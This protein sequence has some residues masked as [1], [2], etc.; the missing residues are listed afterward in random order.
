MLGAAVARRRRRD[1]QG[2]RARARR[3]GPRCTRRLA[4]PAEAQ[5]GRAV[6][7]ERPG[8]GGSG[9]PASTSSGRV[10]QGRLAGP[11]GERD[12]RPTLIRSQKAASPGASVT[13]STTRR[14]PRRAH[15]EWRQISAMRHHRGLGNAAEVDRVGQLE[16]E[17]RARDRARS[18]VR[19]ASE[20]GGLAADLG[21][22]PDIAHRVNHSRR[23][24]G[25]QQRR[26]ATTQPPPASCLDRREG[27]GLGRQLVDLV[28]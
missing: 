11:R 5:R 6:A 18:L 28:L 17:P 24:G 27:L 3:A 13:G 23:G 8:I 9:G 20:R 14:A 7:G 4:P 12:A 26:Q 16:R 15:W 10:V 1:Q 25:T 22:E 2:G 21:A 19:P